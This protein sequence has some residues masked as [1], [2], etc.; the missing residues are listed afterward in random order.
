MDNGTGNT[1]I[2]LPNISSYQCQPTLSAWSRLSGYDNFSIYM[3]M[4]LNR[5]CDVFDIVHLISTAIQA[6]V[7][8]LDPRIQLKRNLLLK[9]LLMFCCRHDYWHVLDLPISEAK[10]YKFLTLP[11]IAIAEKHIPALALFHEFAIV[12]NLPI[13]NDG[14]LCVSSV[15]DVEFW[16]NNDMFVHSRFESSTVFDLNEIQLWDANKKACFIGFLAYT[17]RNLDCVQMLNDLHLLEPRRKP[18]VGTYETTNFVNFLADDQ[19]SYF[20][21]I[22]LWS[23]LSGSSFLISYLSKKYPQDVKLVMSRSKGTNLKTKIRTLLRIMK[24]EE[25]SNCVAEYLLS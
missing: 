23:L 20:V 25:L 12:A 16:T 5:H 3:G 8:Y 7:A 2:Q 18:S 24:N 4:I 19:Y 13:D 11:E 14:P 21:T 15:I 22:I 9:Q 10:M 1:S 6:G 17:R